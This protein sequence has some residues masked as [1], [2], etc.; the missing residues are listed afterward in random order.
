MRL[1]YLPNISREGNEH[2]AISDVRFPKPRRSITIRGVSLD[3]T[4]QIPLVINV[5]IPV[6]N[7]PISGPRCHMLIVGIGTDSSKNND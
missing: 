3:A 6:G 1:M 5:K 2:S 7:Q 4:Y